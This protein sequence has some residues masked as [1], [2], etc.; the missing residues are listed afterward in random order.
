MNWAKFKEMKLREQLQWILQYYGVTI[1]VV[2]AAVFVGTVFIASVFGAEEDYAIRV[3][4]LDDRQFADNCREFSEELGAALSGECDITSYLES[5]DDQRQAF[6]VRLMSDHLDIV[7]APEEQTEQLL[8][9]GFLLQAMRLEADSFYNQ[10]TAPD[11]EDGA[12]CLGVASSGKNVENIPIA[13][14]YFISGSTELS[15]AAS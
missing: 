5:D 9:N 11:R 6:A 4:I 15:N 14:A 7:I 12:I 8:Q 10:R 3:M 1:A 2:I 13:I